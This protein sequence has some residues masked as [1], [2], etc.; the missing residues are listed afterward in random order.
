MM[1]CTIEKWMKQSMVWLAPSTIDYIVIIKLCLGVT[2][3]VRGSEQFR[4]VFKVDQE[5]VED[6]L[7]D[8]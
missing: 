4:K 6:F 5:R 1:P 7:W 2:Y 3:D 8:T